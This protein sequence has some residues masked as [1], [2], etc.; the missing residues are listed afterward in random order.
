LKRKNI[1]QKFILFFL[2]IFILGACGKDDTV[3]APY[4][5]IIIVQPGT[6]A[7]NDGTLTTTWSDQYYTIT[8]LDGNSNPMNNVEIFIDFI[9]AIPDTAGLAQL[10]SGNKES[11]YTAVNAPMV[12]TTDSSGNYHLRVDFSHGGG[13]KYSGT[14]RV[15][16]AGAIHGAAE[17]SVTAS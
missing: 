7:V 11:G 12:A 1:I 17:F 16:S 10:Y 5:S 13:L 8:V 6:T 9:W 4:G 3:S 15:I 14:I 2:I